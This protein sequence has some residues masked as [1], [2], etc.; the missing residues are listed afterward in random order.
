MEAHIVASAIFIVTFYA[1][2]SGKFDRSIAGFAGAM[3]MVVAG[4]ALGFYSQEA[5]FG[6]IDFN[7]MGLLLGMMVI[8]SVCKKTGFFSYVAIKT[9]KA[10]GG[11]PLRLMIMLGCITAFL[12]MALDNVT[13]IILIIPITILVCDILGINPLPMIVSEIVLSNIGGVGTMIGDPPNMMIASSAGFSFNDFI[14]HLFPIVL[15][16]MVL[17]FA[18]LATVFRKDMKKPPKDFRP[19]LDIDERQAIKDGKSLRKVIVAL[20]IV[21]ALFIAQK[22]FGLHH[23]FIALLGAGV[24]LVLVRPNIEEVIKDVEWPVLIFFSSLFVLIG[25]LEHSGLLNIIAKQVARLASL[26]YNLAKVSLLWISGLSSALVGAIPFTTSMLPVIK[27]V[28]A[29]GQETGSLWWVLALGVG[30]GG[31]G[32][33]IGT[34]AG[35]VGLSMSERTRTPIGFRTWLKTATI[36]MLV[37]LIFV[38]ILIR[39]I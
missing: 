37:N 38:T 22:K 11:S 21:F 14:A 8:V 29:L 39:I 28:G 35:V 9:V 20:L 30:F 31:C 2:L 12:S 5:A 4:L 24:V 7:V 17:S 6:T 3:A 25:G 23:S 36:V 10:S 19:I 32:T 33:P 1:I 15:V 27:S 13:T 34:M 16:A 18:V 26:N